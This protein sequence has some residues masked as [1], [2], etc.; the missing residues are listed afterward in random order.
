[1]IILWKKI[2]TD[3]ILSAGRQASAI[4]FLHTPERQ[5]EEGRSHFSPEMIFPKHVNYPVGKPLEVNLN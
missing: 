2:L 4:S 1:M 5:M 3:F